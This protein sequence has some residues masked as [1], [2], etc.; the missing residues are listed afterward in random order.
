MSITLKQWSGSSVAP[1]DDATLYQHLES[2]SG[3]IS[4]CEVTSVGGLQL[5]IASGYGIICGRV[6]AIEQETITATVGSDV[7]G[8]LL[9]VVNTANAQAP[10]SLVTQAAAVLPSLV[11]EDING[12]GSVYQLP[13]ATYTAGQVAITDLQQAFTPL[14]A[15]SGGIDAAAPLGGWTASRAIGSDASGNLAVA[16]T[17][18]TELNYLHGVTAPVQTQLNAKQAAL[19]FD[20]APT[21]NSNNPVRSGG[22]YNALNTV[23]E[24]VTASRDIGV[25]DIGKCLRCLTNNVVLSVPENAS[26]GSAAIPIGSEIMVIRWTLEKTLTVSPKTN[27]V[28]IRSAD[29][30][31][32]ARTLQN[33]GAACLKKIASNEWLLFGALE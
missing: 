15:L 30:Q 19:T 28:Q 21:Q 11:Q 13:L 31:T 14:P 4:G 16:S 2:R 25:S 7:N 17:T 33:Y 10:I 8:R 9:V 5:Q 3:I 29:G 26:S 20:T 12:G 18:T 24:S 1:I 32:G 27:N 23:P 22:V 6:F